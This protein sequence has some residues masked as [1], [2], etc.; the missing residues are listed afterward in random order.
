MPGARPVACSAAMTQQRERRIVAACDVEY[1]RS[2]ERIHAVTE[3]V[4]VRGL[5]VRTDAYIPRGEGVAL[6]VTLPGGGQLRLGTKVAHILPE[7]LARSMGRSAGMGL[8]IV[9][10]PPDRWVTFV[11]SLQQEAGPSDTTNSDFGTSVVVIDRSTPLLERLLTNLSAAGF[12]VRTFSDIFRGL[13]ACSAEP[14]DVLLV[15]VETQGEDA[16]S[17]VKMAATNPRLAQVAVMLM[18]A[19]NSDMV[20]VQAYRHGVRDFITKPFTDEEIC[21]RLRRLAIRDATD[22]HRVALRGSL[23]EVSAGM[24]LA[25][26]EFERKSGALV[27]MRESEVARIYISSGAVHVVQRPGGEDSL[28]NL[29]VVLGWKSGSF[30]FMP[31]VVDLSDEIGLPTS[32][33]LLEHARMSDEGDRGEDGSGGLEIDF[34]EDGEGDGG[35]NFDL[36]EGSDTAGTG[37]WEP[38]APPLVVPDDADAGPLAGADAPDAAPSEGDAGTDDASQDTPFSGE[39]VT[40]AP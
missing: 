18:S 23:D 15:D 29:N 36:G 8:E 39:D 26:L 12:R 27:V 11:E 5:Y 30:E 32:H 10:N 19:E 17:V 34:G 1:V 13:E 37:A 22:D 31:G 24:L 21:I 33:L 38:G 4:G 35:I 14:P 9:G 2:G 7:G 3:D 6:T 25:L 16:A 20:R 40:P 28:A